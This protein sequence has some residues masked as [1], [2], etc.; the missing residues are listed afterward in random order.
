[1]SHIKDSGY[2]ASVGGLYLVHGDTGKKGGPGEKLKK[3]NVR[4]TFKGKVNI[5]ENENIT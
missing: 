2:S 1:M 3:E 5:L 4:R